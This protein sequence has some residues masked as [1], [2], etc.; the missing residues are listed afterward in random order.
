MIPLREIEE[1]LH[2]RLHQVPGNPAQTLQNAR[3]FGREEGLDGPWTDQ[4]TA[5]AY[6]ACIVLL[7]NLRVGI[8]REVGFHKLPFD[9]RDQ[10]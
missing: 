5:R 4:Q 7:E 1:E 2:R 10:T 6:C 8:E 3:R 9:E